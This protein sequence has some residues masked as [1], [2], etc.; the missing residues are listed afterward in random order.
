MHHKN[1][2][3][4][5]IYAPDNL[6]Q[7][8][9]DDIFNSLQTQRNR[10]NDEEL[11]SEYSKLPGTILRIAGVLSVLENVIFI[12]FIIGVEKQ[13]ILTIYICRALGPSI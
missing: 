5:T 13:L 4:K 3:Q 7:L 10:C 1:D 2:A 8:K 12:V 6:G 9:F 11:N